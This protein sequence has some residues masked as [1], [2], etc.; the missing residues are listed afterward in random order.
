MGVSSFG[1]GSHLCGGQEAAGGGE[2]GAEKKPEK[3]PKVGVSDS[4][5][6]LGNEE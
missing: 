3:P 4:P 1:Y 2:G 5:K 6:P